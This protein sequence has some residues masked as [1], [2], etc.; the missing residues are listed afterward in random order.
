MTSIVTRMVETNDM[1]NNLTDDQYS[2]LYY[3]AAEPV[4]LD[5]L[6]KAIRD[7]HKAT[8][9]D[10]PE[11]LGGKLLTT[12]MDCLE[13]V[14]LTMFEAAYDKMLREDSFTVDDE[15]HV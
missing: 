12:L 2:E 5:T 11:K 6:I 4:E 10:R 14:S 13:G 3:E 15:G 8:R 7:M 9:W 1:I